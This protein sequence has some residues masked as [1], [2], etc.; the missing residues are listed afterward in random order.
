MRKPFISLVSLTAAAVLTLSAC[1]TGGEGE[2]TEPTDGGA[3]TA[4]SSP[5]A[6]PEGDSGETVELEYVHRLP[7]G[8]GM[9][10][11]AD[12]VDR[13]NSEHPET[14][15]TATKW[16]GE[17][18]ELVV[19]LEQDVAA[20]NA[21][22]LAQV[23][24]GEVPDLFVKGL[25]EDV[26]QYG[27]QYKGDFAEG[28]YSAMTVGETVVGLPQ[29]VGPLIYMYNASEFEKLGIEVPTTL[30]EFTTAAQTAAG[31]DKKIAAFMPD[32]A[33][34]WLSGQAA[35]AGGVWYK[36][37]NDQ[38]VVDAN[39]EA[40]K[41]VADFYQGLLDNDAAFV[42]PRWA[43]SFE[44]GLTSGELIGYIAPAW[45]VGFALD[46]LDGTEYEGQW[47]VAQLPDFGQGQISGPDGGSGVAVMK[48]CEHPEQ[49]MEFN[50]WFN[51]QIDDLASQG[52]VVATQ[53]APATPEKTLRQF[54][55]QDV[56]SELATAATNMNPDF[57]YAPGFGTVA[58]SMNTA[59]EAA[60]NGNGKVADVFEA[61]QTASVAALEDRGLPVAES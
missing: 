53:E 29:D 18:A 59:A 6:A 8:E 1:G 16:D 36:A 17:A 15:V 60:G 10:P 54:G 50:H 4:V 58:D 14:Q 26:S 2:N 24:Y 47:R 52:L 28:A 45:E 61:A 31:K 11:V 46:G 49:A 23:G 3:T 25:F 35:A 41:T 20:G 39:S 32:E 27:E 34:Y 43:E 33:L 21:P 30:D 13:W 44:A 19:K 57:V 48:G 42:S 55:D 9:T 56:Y 5:E 12:I 51:T 40:S 38:W 37:E 7:D 22:C